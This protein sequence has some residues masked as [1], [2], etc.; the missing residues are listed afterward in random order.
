MLPVVKVLP[1]DTFAATPTRTDINSATAAMPTT[2]RVFI[3]LPTSQTSIGHRIVRS[4]STRNAHAP[5][6]PAAPG[7]IGPR[8]SDGA[9]VSVTES[10]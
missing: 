10:V 1:S 9:H 2:M 4:R 6:Q 5:R 7:V 8:E 3:D